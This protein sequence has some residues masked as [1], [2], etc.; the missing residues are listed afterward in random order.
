M[1]ASATADGAALPLDFWC[2]FNSDF[3]LSG[4]DTAVT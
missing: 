3:A 4:N 2:G 1:S